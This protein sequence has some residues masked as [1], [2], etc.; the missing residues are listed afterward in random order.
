MIFLL[1]ILRLSYVDMQVRRL[2]VDSPNMLT[3]LI[4]P[5][6]GLASTNQGK[7]SA[8]MTFPEFQRA[9]LNSC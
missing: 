5:S 8:S 3:P 4:C 6:R 2:R 9:D 1:F 7:T